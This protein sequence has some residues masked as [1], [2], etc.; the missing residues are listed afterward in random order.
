MRKLSRLMVVLGLTLVV[1]ATSLVGLPAL[2]SSATPTANPKPGLSGYGSPSTEA[3]GPYQG[4]ALPEGTTSDAATDLLLN[5]RGTEVPAGH[6]VIQ[7]DASGQGLV[8]I[9]G[10]PDPAP[11]ANS[12]WS[13]LLAVI[14]AFGAGFGLGSGHRQRRRINT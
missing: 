4:R 8:Q 14:A 3:C 5:N 1:L 9:C 10:L 11:T 2:G 7:Q 6:W 12:P 13:W